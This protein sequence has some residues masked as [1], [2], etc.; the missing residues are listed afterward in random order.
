VTALA[1]HENH[2][3]VELPTSAE[4]QAI[5]G[6][7]A[8]VPPDQLPPAA[9]AIIKECG[10]LPLALALCGG[11]VHGGSSWSNVLAALQEHDLEFLSSEHPDEAQ[12][13]N[14]WKAMDISMRILP[15]DE[16][17][18][19]AE[20]AVFGADTGAPAAAVATLWEHTAGLSP[21][22]IDAL[23]AKFSRR[24]LVQRPFAADG[25]IAAHVDLHDLLHHFATTRRCAYFERKNC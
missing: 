7:A 13:Q 1:A 16:Q 19:F 24:P 25:K 23:L 18:R 10:R 12:H 8:G 4:A 15:A 2:Y 5:L 11:M 3:R 20:L 17:Q 9:D 21:R 6:G 14:A 22:Q